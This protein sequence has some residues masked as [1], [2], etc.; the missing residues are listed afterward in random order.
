M[1]NNRKWLLSMG[2]NLVTIAAVA[3]SSQPPPAVAEVFTKMFPTARNVDWKEKTANFTAFFNLNDRK[4]EAKFA[5]AGNW[6]NTEETITWDSLPRPVQEAF[7]ASKYA[8]WNPV[9]AYSIRSGEGTAEFHLVVSKIDQSRKILFFNPDGK[10]LA[11][12]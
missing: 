8:E 3:Q 5:K 7:K 10:L 4:C 11:D 6:L 2:L 1:K 12:R 9:S